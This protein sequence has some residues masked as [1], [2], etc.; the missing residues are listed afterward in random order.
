[1]GCNCSRV[2]SA[3]SAYPLLHFTLDTTIPQGTLDSILIGIVTKKLAIEKFCGARLI[4]TLSTYP[5]QWHPSYEA[6][7]EFTEIPHISVEDWI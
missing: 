6:M 2:A 3:L 5:V 1:M 7:K 4:D